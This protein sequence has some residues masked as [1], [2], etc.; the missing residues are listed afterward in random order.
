MAR[1]CVLE[2]PTLRRI[3]PVAPHTSDSAPATS[4][5]R[6]SVARILPSS[7]VLKL[8]RKTG[9]ASLCY[10]NSECCSH[11]FHRLLQPSFDPWFTCPEAG[12]EV[13]FASYLRY[14]RPTMPPMQSGG[15]PVPWICDGVMCLFVQLTVNRSV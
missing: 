1:G 9:L 12:Y 3:A 8:H 2:L 14:D 10:F 4:A 15:L 7:A 13:V 5:G 6:Y 11:L